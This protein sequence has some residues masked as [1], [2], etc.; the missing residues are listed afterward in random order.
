MK[1]KMLIFLVIVIF[2][3]WLFSQQIERI[4]QKLPEVSDTKSKITNVRRWYYSSEGQWNSNMSMDFEI[5]EVKIENKIYVAFISWYT[6][7]SDYYETLDACTYYVFDKKYLDDF[8]TSDIKFNKSYCIDV[9]VEYYDQKE[10]LKNWGINSANLSS[11]ISKQIQR[12]KNS[13]YKRIPK[14]KFFGFPVIYKGKR[15]MRFI[16]EDY[17]N[18]F[19]DNYK[20]KDTSIFNEM[21][22]ELEYDVFKKFI[23]Y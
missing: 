5:R 20:T 15:L 12:D 16:L 14:L 7:I 22:F 6:V 23:S 4:S 19:D 8:L 9:Q 17:L 10:D 3:K 21:Y 11:K 2:S 18:S 1:V 13:S